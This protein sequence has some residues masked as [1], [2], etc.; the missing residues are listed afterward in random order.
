LFLN[1]K[2]QLRIINAFFLIMTFGLVFPPLAVVICAS[3]WSETC[4]EQFLMCRLLGE[5]EAACSEVGLLYWQR[6]ERDV[7]DLYQP[8][9][10]SLLFM[11]LTTS[12]VFYAY[13]A[14]DTLGYSQGWKVGVGGASALLGAVVALTLAGTNAHACRGCY[15]QGARMSDAFVNIIV[16]QRLVDGRRAPAN[17]ETA[18]QS[19]LEMYATPFTFLYPSAKF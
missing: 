7:R 12:A 5:A 15:E 13:F 11:L 8:F 18:R 3:V 2:F 4:F 1:T 10:R 19:N 14:F 6:L 17:D 9:N 16:N